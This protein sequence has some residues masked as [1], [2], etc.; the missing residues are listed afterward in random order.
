MEEVLAAERFTTYGTSHMVVIALLLVGAVA[1]IWVGRAYRGTATAERLGKLL[2]AA[3]LLFTVPAQLLYFTPGSF[4]LER[5]LPLQLCDLA[6]MVSAYGLWTHRRWA[7]ALTYYWGLTLTTQAVATPDLAVNF[8]DR[9]F[10][11]FWGMHLLV[12]W[13]AVYLTWGL[14]LTPDWRSYRTAFFVTAAW[15]AAVFSFN[16][17]ADT[18]YGYL[19][20]K[21]AAASVL[22]LLGPWPWYVLAEVVIIATVWA[23]L[24]W[25]WVA[26]AAKR[27]PKS[28]KPGRLRPA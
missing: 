17:V 18:N 20:E 3:T 1:L 11:V 10:I 23:L 8:P 22:D 13:G 4:D 9:G 6:W 25:P 12:V 15:A 26:L 5:T 28:A 19:N 14:N 24:T 7:V 2:A 21:P 16:L 27:G